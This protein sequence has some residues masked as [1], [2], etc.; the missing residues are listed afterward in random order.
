MNLDTFD[1]RMP[2][3]HAIRLVLSFLLR[4][5]FLCTLRMGLLNS[6]SNGLDL[7]RITLV[8]SALVELGTEKARIWP[9]TQELNPQSAFNYFYICKENMPFSHV[10]CTW[11][12]FLSALL[13][14]SFEWPGRSS[15]NGP[16]PN[17]NRRVFI[18]IL[19]EE[20]FATPIERSYS[21]TNRRVLIKIPIERLC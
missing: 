14:A 2:P 16:C 18:E 10:Q 9:L 15:S 6:S 21:D 19:I 7:K 17:I 13:M 12:C 4:M 5:D 1:F 3:G 20:S 11:T 8:E